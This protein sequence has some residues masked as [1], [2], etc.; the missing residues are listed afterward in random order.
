MIAVT[1]CYCR[2]PLID[3]LNMTGTLEIV[4]ELQNLVKEHASKE[5]KKAVHD[6]LLPD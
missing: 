2:T 1:R 4:G 3:L 6:R 5:E